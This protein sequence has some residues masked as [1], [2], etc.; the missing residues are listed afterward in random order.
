VGGY[1]QNLTTKYLIL[2]VA[3][4]AFLAAIIFVILAAFWGLAI[5]TQNIVQAAGIMAVIL[6]VLGFFIVFIAYGIEERK[7]RIL[8]DPMA[9]LRAEVPSV[10]EIGDHIEEAVHHYGPSKVVMAAAVA[11]IVAGLASRRGG[12]SPF[13]N[14]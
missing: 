8:S 4:L 5:W 2:S 7:P 1:V 14:V 10:D 3:G 9:S 13:R 12:I 11:G 6:A